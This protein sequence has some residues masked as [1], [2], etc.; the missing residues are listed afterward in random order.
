MS[1]KCPL[2]CPEHLFDTPGTLFGHFLGTPETGAPK[3]PADTL[4][5]NLSDTPVFRDTLGEPAHFGPEG[6][7]RL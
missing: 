5:D 7:E 6:P 3:R 4:W 1:Q 2:E